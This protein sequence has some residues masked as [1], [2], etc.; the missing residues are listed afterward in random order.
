MEFFCNMILMY[1]E[2]FSSVND[3]NGDDAIHE[4]GKSE[5][6]WAEHC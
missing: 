2:P 1:T 4:I 6:L 5:M 3:N